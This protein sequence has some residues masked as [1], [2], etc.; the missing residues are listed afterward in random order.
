MALLFACSFVRDLAISIVRCVV[1]CG[2]H[3]RCGGLLLSSMDPFGAV[4]PEPY[5][6]ADWLRALGVV[7]S[8]AL[9]SIRCLSGADSSLRASKE[10]HLFF[11]DIRCVQVLGE[12]RHRHRF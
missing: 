11:S 8:M 3:V 5:L 12:T 2:V 1:C 7:T 4:Q 10:L 6:G 9:A